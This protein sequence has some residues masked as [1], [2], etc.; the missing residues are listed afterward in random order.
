[1]EHKQLANFVFCTKKRWCYTTG[2]CSALWS[3]SS[4]LIFIRLEAHDF[5]FIVIS[6]CVRELKVWPQVQTTCYIIYP[7]RRDC[8]FVHIYSLYRSKSYF[9]PPFWCQLSHLCIITMWMTFGQSCFF[10]SS[11]KII[12]L[13]KCMW[14]ITYWRKTYMINVQFF[15]SVQH[16]HHYIAV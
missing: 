9:S 7:F 2:M 6:L 8:M 3:K 16:A 1:M 12:F 4:L 13:L 14:L 5:L 11:V 15:L 10:F